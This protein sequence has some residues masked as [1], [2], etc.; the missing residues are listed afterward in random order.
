MIVNDHMKTYRL[1]FGTFQALFVIFDMLRLLRDVLI[2][3]RVERK[4]SHDSEREGEMG[5]N[6]RSSIEAEFLRSDAWIR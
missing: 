2:S 4:D 5:E 1:L 3:S 6:G